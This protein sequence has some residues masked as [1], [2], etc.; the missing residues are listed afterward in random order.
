MNYSD[1]K[2]TKPKSVEELTRLWQELLGTPPAR[3]QFAYWTA[4]HG[5][6]ATERAVVRTG[7]KKLALGGRM[8]ADY[9]VRYTSSVLNNMKTQQETTHV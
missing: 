8:D 2:I 6:E 7:R 4:A 9:Q 1:L 5:A 3:E